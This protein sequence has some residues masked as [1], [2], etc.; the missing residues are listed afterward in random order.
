MPP[1]SS[2]DTALIVRPGSAPGRRPPSASSAATWAPNSSVGGPSAAYAARAGGP[3]H[4]RMVREMLSGR[5]VRVEDATTVTGAA[6]GRGRWRRPRGARDGLIASRGR[7]PGAGGGDD[8]GR[9]CGDHLG[10]GDDGVPQTAARRRRARRRRRRR[11][12]R[13]GARRR[14]GA[15]H[16]LRAERGGRQR[17]DGERAAQLALEGPAGRALLDVDAHATGPR[18]EQRLRLLA[19]DQPGPAASGTERQTSQRLAK[20]LHRAVVATL[21]LLDRVEALEPHDRLRREV[22]LVPPHQDAGVLVGEAAQRFEDRLV[23]LPVRA[24]GVDRLQRVVEHRERALVTLAVLAQRVEGD[25][26]RTRGA[27]GLA[28]AVAVALAIYRRVL[29]DPTEPGDGVLPVGERRRLLAL[30]GDGGAPE[31]VLEEIGEVLLPERPAE[32]VA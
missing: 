32:L 1:G 17:D 2:R 6:D 4:Q 24:V 23:D 26:G 14:A 25:V 8:P 11:G 13:G 7:E 5:F 10:L 3:V 22:V 27:L 18:V 16:E 19:Q 21:V 28:A 30:Q 15:E 9:Q 29:A 20:R 12:L 31:S